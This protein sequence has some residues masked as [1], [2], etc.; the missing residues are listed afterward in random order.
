MGT[1]VSKTQPFARSWSAYVQFQQH[2]WSVQTVGNILGVSLGI[3]PIGPFQKELGK[4]KGLLRVAQPIGLL[5]VSR[6]FRVVLASLV[7]T[8]KACWGAILNGCVPVNTC[9]NKQTCHLASLC[10]A[11]LL[12][13]VA[14]PV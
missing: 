12:T 7:L 3:F 5:P 2:G 9:L 4:E 14:S 13:S 8:S 10:P 11:P 6:R 1:N